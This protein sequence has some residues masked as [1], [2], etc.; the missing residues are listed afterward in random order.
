MP[1]REELERLFVENL[2]T[3]D[4]V[5]AALCR[6]YGIARDDVDDVASWVKARL[7]ESD[8]AALA[9]FRGESSLATYLTVVVAMLFRD[10]RAQKWGR[11]RPSVAAQR[12]GA[13]AVRLETLVVRDHVPL[14]QAGEM[15]RS[16]GDTEMSDRDLA[17]LLA[18]L[19]SRE[20]LRPVEV[21]ADALLRRESAHRADARLWTQ[22]TDAERRALVRHLDD[23]LAQLPPED[24]VM[25]RLRYWED[26]S[27]ADIARTLGVEQKPLYRRLDRALRDLRKRLE[28][29][30]VSP[31]AFAFLQE[32]AEAEVA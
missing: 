16:A 9:R 31:D 21:G 7:I 1:E 30:G 29:S 4:R 26:V 32:S 10:Y 8:Y 19:P 14:R 28:A 20:A 12:R 17:E 18:Q 13:V 2:G 6:R 3:I 15:L 24:R 11:W 5:I 27:V 23:A 25:L 22:E